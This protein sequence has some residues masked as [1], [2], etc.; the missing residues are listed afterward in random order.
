MTKRVVA[1]AISFDGPLFAKDPRLS[2]LQNVREL[3]A[4]VAALGEADVKA[5]IAAI[6]P[7]GVRTGRTRRRYRGRTRSLR[8]KPWLY[9]AVISPDTTGLSAAEARA[10][11]AAA[12]EIEGRHRVVRRTKARLLRLIRLQRDMTRGLA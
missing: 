11:M 6:P 2:W 5:Q 3:M 12:S 1:T 8:G 9:T 4:E 10:V 7:A